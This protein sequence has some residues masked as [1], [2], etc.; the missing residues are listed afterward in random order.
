[1]VKINMEKIRDI[2]EKNQF[3]MKDGIIFPHQRQLHLYL[4]GTFIFQYNYAFK[5]T[6]RRFKVH[7]SMHQYVFFGISVYVPYRYQAT[8]NTLMFQVTRSSNPIINRVA[9]LPLNLL[10]YGTSIIVG[11]IA[12]RWYWVYKRGFCAA[13]HATL[14]TYLMY[15][16]YQNLPKKYPYFQ[17]FR[18]IRPKLVQ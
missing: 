18:E 6:P 10:V 5:T 9:R 17:A 3:S 2:G 1:M 8:L 4:I 15:K 11:Q 7:R 13:K 14:N 16:T 12:A